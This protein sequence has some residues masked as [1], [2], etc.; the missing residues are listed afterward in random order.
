MNHTEVLPEQHHHKVAPVEKRAFD[1]SDSGKL[2]RGLEDERQKYYDTQTRVEGEKTR[3]E[4]PTVQGEHVHHHVHE[5][6]QPVV[7]KRMPPTSL[8]S[9]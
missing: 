3:T 7:N 2:S 5:T 1:H 6:I 4:N 9:L 8:F